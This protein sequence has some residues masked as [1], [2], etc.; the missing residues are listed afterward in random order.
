MG[1]GKS[2]PTENTSQATS[3]L[4]SSG[5]DAETGYGAAN[6]LL[7]ASGDR[8]VEERKCADADADAD[9]EKYQGVQKPE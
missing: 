4:R 3:R 5:F 8:D 6:I 9:A 2:K 1:V 7:R